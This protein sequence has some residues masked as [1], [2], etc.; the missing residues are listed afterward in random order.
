MSSGT[1]IITS[2]ELHSWD[3][4]SIM[5]VRNNQIKPNTQKTQELAAYGEEI[6]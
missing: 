4:V 6:N 3:I 2:K 1:I 5:C